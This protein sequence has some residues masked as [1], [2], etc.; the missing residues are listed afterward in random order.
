MFYSSNIFRSETNPAYCRSETSE[1][2]LSDIIQCDGNASLDSV[3]SNV[4]EE[5]QAIPVLISNRAEKASS[6][7]QP[8]KCLMQNLIRIKRNN[9]ITEAGNLPIVINLN[10]R[11]LYNKADEFKTLISQT[12]ASLCF[13]SESWDRSHVQGGSRLEDTIKIEGYRW[14]VN[15]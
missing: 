2:D 8:S 15:L 4:L 7:N 1:S 11:S 5:G 10:P 13:I 9:K 3:Y 14:G 6:C 12:D